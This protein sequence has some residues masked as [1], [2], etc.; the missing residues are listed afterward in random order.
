MEAFHVEV[1]GIPHCK[2]CLPGDGCTNVIYQYHT[3]FKYDVVAHTMPE[4]I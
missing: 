4:I 1:A 3:D 2:L